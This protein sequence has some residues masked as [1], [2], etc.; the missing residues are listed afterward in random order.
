MMPLGLNYEQ[1]AQ[2]LQDFQGY[3]V[4]ENPS[5]IPEPQLGDVIDFALVMGHKI[6]KRAVGRVIG[7][8]TRVDM[9]SQLS[10][11]DPLAIAL[12]HPESTFSKV[13]VE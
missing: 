6:H 11:V 4:V 13:P 2:W 8:A 1:E 9:I 7:K 3:V 5:P 10:M 12:L